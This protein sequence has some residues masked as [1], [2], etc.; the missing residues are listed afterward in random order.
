[1]MREFN[2]IRKNDKNPKMSDISYHH[3]YSLTMKQNENNQNKTSLNKV[4]Q[5]IQCFFL[6]KINFPTAHRTHKQCRKTET[7]VIMEKKKLLSV[8]K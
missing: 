8:G 6:K 5:W 7:R 4:N 2:L 3:F 1:M